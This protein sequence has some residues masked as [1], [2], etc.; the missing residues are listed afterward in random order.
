V[1]EAGVTIIEG[2]S[3]SRREWADRLCFS[4]WVETPRD[5]RLRRGL[6]REGTDALSAWNGWMA[7]EDEFFAR[8]KPWERATAIVP[9]TATAK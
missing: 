1:P 8:D 2:V 7:V 9:G 3:S 5:E 4:V 6:E